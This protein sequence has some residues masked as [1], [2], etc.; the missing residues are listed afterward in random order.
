MSLALA[1]PCPISLLQAMVAVRAG[2][3]VQPYKPFSSYM[4]NNSSFPFPSPCL[5]LSSLKK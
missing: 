3:Y 2:L 5:P 4:S 1:H